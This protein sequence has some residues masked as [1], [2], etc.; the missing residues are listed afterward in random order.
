MGYI[1]TYLT[2]DEKLFLFSE[3]HIDPQ[4]NSVRTRRIQNA[5][6][7]DKTYTDYY[8]NECGWFSS[9]TE[10]QKNIYISL[11]YISQQNRV[12]KKSQTFLLKR[13][14]TPQLVTRLQIGW[15]AVGWHAPDWNLCPHTAHVF[16]C[17]I[18]CF[19]YP[20]CSVLTSRRCTK[21]HLACC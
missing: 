11:S 9:H 15:T 2:Q 5:T 21:K 6:Q 1:R 12:T 4:L 20:S 13:D 8:Q 19:P 14:T 10:I 16:V 7:D 3:T 17:V 18:L